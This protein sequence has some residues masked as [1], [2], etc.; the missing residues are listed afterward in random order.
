MRHPQKYTRAI[1]Y[2]YVYSVSDYPRS[3]M[4]QLILVVSFGSMHGGGRSADVWRSSP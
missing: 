4:D 1:N 2:T 3:E